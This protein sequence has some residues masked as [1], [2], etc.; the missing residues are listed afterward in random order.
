[1][2][3]WEFL[4][5]WQG[6]R[7]A[8]GITLSVLAH[9]LLLAA[10][11]TNNPFFATSRT[12]AGDALIVDLQ[13]DPS[14]AAPGSAAPPPAA[15]PQ[16]A[17]PRARPAAT[18]PSPRARPAPPAPVP[19]AKPAP[20]ADKPAPASETPPRVASAPPTPA[21]PEP[22]APQPAPPQVTDPAGT[23]PVPAPAPA[24]RT[25][26]TVPASSAPPP[27]PPAPASGG[28]QQVASAP[29]AAGAPPSR[30]YVPD[31]RSLRP[32]AGGA[33]G[34]SGTGRGGVEG[35]PV[36]LD[37]GDPRYGEYLARVK[38]AIEQKMTYPCEKD[39]HGRICEPK[40]AQL[41]L[42]FG[43]KPDGSLAFIEV[44]RPAAYRIFDDASQIAVKLATFPPLPESLRRIHPT[45]IPILANFRYTTEISL[46][47]I[48][49]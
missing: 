23:L 21:P 18:P 24:A 47:S 33:H 36:A 30:A 5:Q 26:T 44:R 48:L 1:M 22:P 4:R 34:L 42:E 31:L 46:R 43:I 45:G 9:A 10:L 3:L 6:S 40:Q 28:Q 20:P 19:A 15:P 29:P 27:S 25:D 37:S 11:F 35:D 39:P 12:K 7:H 13:S 8:T 14:P 49:R 2:G 16:P 38:L 32:G 17:A 41:L